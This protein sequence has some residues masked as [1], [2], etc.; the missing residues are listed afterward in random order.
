VKAFVVACAVGFIIP[1][2]TLLIGA[3][4]YLG[5]AAAAIYLGGSW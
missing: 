3:F 2:A 4:V 1:A 5:E